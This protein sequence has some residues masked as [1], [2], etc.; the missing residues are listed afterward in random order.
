MKTQMKKLMIVGAMAAASVAF[1]AE[2]SYWAQ[3]YDATLTMKT[4]VCKAG[5]AT[6]ATVKYYESIWGSGNAPVEKGDEMGFRKQATR[7]ISGLF[8]GCECET[9]AFPA[10]RRYS[11]QD[12]NGKFLGG[13]AFWDQAADTYF[14]LPNTVF[15]WGILNRIN[16]DFKTVEGAWVL[17]NNVNP[18]ALYLMGAGFGKASIATKRCRS[19]ISKISGSFAGFRFP[20]TD[21]LVGSCPYCGIDGCTVVPFCDL[22]WFWTANTRLTAA[23]GTWSIKFNKKAAN[24]LKSKARIT[25]SY[26]F[27]KAGNLPLVLSLMEEFVEKLDKKGADADTDAAYLMPADEVKA[28]Y[29][30]AVSGGEGVVIYNDGSYELSESYSEDY[31]DYEEAYL[32]KL[33]YSL[34]TEEDLEGDEEDCD[35]CGSENGAEN[36]AFPSV[37]EL[38]NKVVNGDAGSEEDES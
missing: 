9:I 35:E 14:V 8:W 34:I 6:A 13:Y 21:D 16:N 22:C 5:K 37:V 23:Y 10:W 3:V 30:Y 19:I 20:G 4:G 24:K 38:I 28:A 11:P 36:S 18:Q 25:Q 29:L 2:A 1:G 31:S 33:R 15:G 27:K 17:A 7:K 12:G 26:T 32:D